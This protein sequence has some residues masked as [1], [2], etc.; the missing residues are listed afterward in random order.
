MKKKLV[1]IITESILETHLVKD[2]KAL[3]AKGYTIVDSRGSGDHGLR[4]ADWSQNQNIR[5]EIIC[6]DTTAQLIIDHLQKIYYANYA[7]VVFTN[8]IKVL[9]PE[10]F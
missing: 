10:K 9:R 1:T 4:N 2:I 7:M 8:D 3:G 5:I 6:N